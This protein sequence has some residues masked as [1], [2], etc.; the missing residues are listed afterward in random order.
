MSEGTDHARLFA[1]T[2]P[3]NGSASTLGSNGVNQFPKGQLTLA[4]R[5]GENQSTNLPLLERLGMS[6]EREPLL[7]QRLDMVDTAGEKLQGTNPLDLRM[8]VPIQTTPMGMRNL[9]PRPNASNT[10]TMS[11]R[12]SERTKLRSSKHYPKS[13]PSSTLALLEPR[14]LR[15]PLSSTT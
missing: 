13:S 12:T 7:L 6:E 8:N 5:L 9:P 11:S 1:S 14:K 2:T 15:T 4:A 3:G 10:W